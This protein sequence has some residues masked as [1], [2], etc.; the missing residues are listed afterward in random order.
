VTSNGNIDLEV[1]DRSLE[2]LDRWIDALKDI[3]LVSVGIMASYLTLSSGGAIGIALILVI[4]AV[5][6]FS[7]IFL[8]YKI[9]ATRKSLLG[10]FSRYRA[11]ELMLVIFVSWLVPTGLVL[12]FPE[13]L[14]YLPPRSET[15]F[16]STL[17]ILVLP[18]VASISSGLFGVLVL[19][20]IFRRIGIADT[21]FDNYE[22]YP[23]GLGGLGPLVVSQAFIYAQ[24]LL[25]QAVQMYEQ[26]IDL[27]GSFYARA[28]GA[29]IVLIMLCCTLAYY[30]PKRVLT[31]KGELL[32]GIIG[33][34]VLVALWEPIIGFEI[35]F[36]GILVLIWYSLSLPT[37]DIKSM[38][39]QEERFKEYEDMR[40]T[41]L[42]IKYRKKAQLLYY[43]R[44][45]LQIIGF[46]GIILFVV[47]DIDNEY[48]M[49]SYVFLAIFTFGMVLYFL[50]SSLKL[51]LFNKYRKYIANSV[52]EEKEPSIEE[53]FELLGIDAR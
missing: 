29:L 53:L 28:F 26:S 48:P 15:Q 47:L 49:L 17:L 44:L 31:T 50:E 20:K 5:S 41:L 16:V 6:V 22:K 7:S 9:A 11:I 8:P 46:G 38:I 12:L 30:E 32:F 19:L 34:G 23:W 35:S 42:H 39:V 13:I 25:L 43:I 52:N 40:K 33:L 3:F 4:L 1:I 14:I 18:Y 21:F 51:N 24:L 45:M 2:S 36:A 10:I 27:A 37:L